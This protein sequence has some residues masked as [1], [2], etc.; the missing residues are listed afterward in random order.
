M[1]NGATSQH[2]MKQQRL[3][4]RLTQQPSAEMMKRSN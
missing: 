3:T 1:R 4:Q 2:M